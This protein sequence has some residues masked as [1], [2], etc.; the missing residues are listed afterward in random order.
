MHRIPKGAS[1]YDGTAGAGAVG[2]AAAKKRGCSVVLND[3]NPHA[4]NAIRENIS[5]NLVE[6]Q[7]GSALEA[8]VEPERGTAVV[9]CGDFLTVYQNRCALGWRFNHVLILSPHLAVE[10]LASL[11]RHHRERQQKQTLLLATQLPTLHLFCKGGRDPEQLLAK[12]L[13]AAGYALDCIGYGTLP[14]N[15]MTCQPDGAKKFAA[16]AKWFVHNLGN[17][18]GGKSLWYIEIPPRS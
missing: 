16:A 15:D 4:A 17:L 2:I 5:L 13:C 12:L 1:I 10:F 9:D 8:Q 7:H 14:F 3:L 6:T 11:D 18:Y